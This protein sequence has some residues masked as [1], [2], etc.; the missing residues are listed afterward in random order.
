MKIVT[1]RGQRRVAGALS[2]TPA[3]TISKATGI[4]AQTIRLIGVGQPPRT[5][6]AKRLADH[7]AFPFI[8]W[9]PDST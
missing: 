1:S 2:E 4:P 6:T 5:D 9:E 8:E 3:T 7:I